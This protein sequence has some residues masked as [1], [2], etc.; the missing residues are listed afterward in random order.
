MDAEN[1]QKPKTVTTID[2]NWPPKVSS[3]DWLS[4]CVD[5]HFHCVLCG[6]ELHF[7][8]KTDF[9]TQVVEEVAVCPSCKVK[10]RESQHTLQ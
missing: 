4:E 6:T 3:A 8:H 1:N 2:I 9:I 5:E 7:H 10:N